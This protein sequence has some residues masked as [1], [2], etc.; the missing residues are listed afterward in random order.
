MNVIRER[1]RERERGIPDKA[2]MSLVE[3]PFA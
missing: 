2:T 1:E 3:R